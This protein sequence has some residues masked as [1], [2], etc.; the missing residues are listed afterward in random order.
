M[1]T[2]ASQRDYYEVLGVPRDAAPE[3]IK[4][5]YKKLALA[6]HPDRNP[7]DEAAVLRFKE[8]SE[9]YEVLGSAEK[10][11]RYDRYGH[12]GVRG[13]GG[14]GGFH[15][16]GDIFE[17]F[18]DIFEGFGFGR[19]RSRSRAR[20]GDSLRV[21]LTIDLLSAARGANREIEF[22]RHEICTTCGGNGA[23]PGTTPEACD[24]CGGQGQVI[25][26]QGFFRV[27]TVCPACRGAGTIVRDKCESCRGTGREAQRVRREVRIPAGIDDGQQLRVPGE[28]GPGSTE[29]LRGDL[30][31]EVRIE[32][33][34]L[35]RREGRML[36]CAIPITYTQAALGTT[37]EVPTLD[38]AEEF[39]VP[40]GTQ[41]GEVFQLRGKG[42][43]DVHGGRRGDLLVEVQVEVPRKLDPAQE[44]LLRKLAE[45]EKAN[46]STHRKS[47]FEKLKEYFA[48]ADEDA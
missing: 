35:F 8:A 33:H 13:H 3:Q 5:A 37:L 23:K 7:G 10:R 45:V 30:Y 46:V 22:E 24:Y 29:G 21:S 36:A 32:P 17:A 28:G 48:P 26:S 44:E 47:F 25:Q 42:M 9:A 16:I 39:T 34:P 11:A 19:G 4:K 20:R 15:D 2:M 43:P 40:A 12:A 27:Q 6:N 14:A 38:G 18:G 1:P 41:P 31:V